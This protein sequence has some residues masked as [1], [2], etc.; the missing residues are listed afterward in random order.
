MHSAQLLS[1][2]SPQ[3]PTSSLLQG[4]AQ[5]EGALKLSAVGFTSSDRFLKQQQHKVLVWL[6]SNLKLWRQS[7][8]PPPAKNASAPGAGAVRDHR[9]ALLEQRRASRTQEAPRK[10]LGANCPGRRDWEIKPTGDSSGVGGCE[11]GKV[12][13]ARKDWGCETDTGRNFYFSNFTKKPAGDWVVCW[14]VGRT[15]SD[16]SLL[17]LPSPRPRE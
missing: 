6:S 15:R 9:A 5:Q 4:C 16:T 1:T 10:S 2:T 7:C 11:V 8:P 14:G 12:G 13:A 3:A 17:L